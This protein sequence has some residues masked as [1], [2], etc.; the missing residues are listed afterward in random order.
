M[1]LISSHLDTRLPSMALRIALTPST[2]TLLRLSLCADLS[3]VLE[4]ADIM[5]DRPQTPDPPGRVPSTVFPL[6]IV[7]A[8]SMKKTFTSSI[9]SLLWILPI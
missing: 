4:L 8:K 6:C 2:R 1:E 3:L 7:P 5:S 9:I